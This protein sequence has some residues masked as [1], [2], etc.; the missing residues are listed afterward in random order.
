MIKYRKAILKDERNLFALA[1]NLATSFVPNEKD[2]NN[3]Y[4]LLLND[5]N[6]DIYVTEYES[7]LIGY[8]LA[9]HHYTFYANGLVSWVEELYVDEEYRGNNIGKALMQLVEDGAKIRNSK[10]IALATRRASKF[11]EAIGYEKSA[12]YYKRTI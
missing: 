3:V 10:L 8:V 6:V 9:F 4:P 5:K 2:F 11:Y 12:T 7:K 1:K